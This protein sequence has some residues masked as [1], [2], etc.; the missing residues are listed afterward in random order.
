MDILKTT[1]IGIAPLCF[2]SERLANPTDPFTRELKKLTAQKRKTDE[3]QEQIKWL[4]WRA[5][6]YEHE[7]RAVVPADNVLAVVVQGARKLKKGKDASAGVFEAEPQFALRYK[8]ADTI[9][10]L[11]GDHRFC[12]YRSVVVG[13]RRVMRARPIF[14]HWEL[15]IALHFDPEILSK[16]ELVQSLMLGG[17][18]VGLCERRPRW[19][20]FTVK[21]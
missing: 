1:L 15:P 3:L 2:H 7:G 4:E 11:K 6:F 9:E 17:E 16:E 20:R 19:G 13:G 21:S 8:G 14:K 5:G 10:G 18:R 12:D